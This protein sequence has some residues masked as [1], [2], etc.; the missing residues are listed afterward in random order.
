MAGGAFI[1]MIRVAGFFVLI[2]GASKVSRMAGISSIVLEITTGL[3]FSPNILGLMPKEYS[4]CVFKLY[5][6]CE[7]PH[8]VN[9]IQDHLQGCDY[10][11]YM[12]KRGGVNLLPAAVDI[13]AESHSDAGHSSGSASHS[14]GSGSDHGSSLDS[15]SASHSSAS[16]DS[17]SSA[18]QSSSHADSSDS[19][20]SASGDSHSSSDHS[21]NRRLDAFAETRARTIVPNSPLAVGSRRLSADAKGRVTYPTYTE[22]LKKACVLDV[23][24][25][26]QL[27]PNIF[28][29]VGHAGVA[30]MIFESGMHFDFE[31][32]K[33]VGKWACVVAVLGT[34]L[35]LLTGTALI[36]L[37]V[38]GSGLTT[39][40]LSAGT[41]LAPTSVGIALKLLN[42][43]K[44]LQKD[45]GQI[46]ITAAFVDDILSLVL[47][48]VLFSMADGELGFMTFLP[49]ICGLLLMGLVIMYAATKADVHIEMMLAMMPQN[50]PKK[51]LSYQDEFLFFF[52]M[53]MVLVFGT[54][55]FYTGTHLWGCFMA[56]MCLAKLH[57]AH[58]VWVKQTKRMTVWMIR[59]FFSCTVAFSIP[60]SAL[61][62]FGAIWKG[63]LM[64]IGPCIATKVFCAFF[65]GEMRFVVGWAMVGRA[66]FAYLIAQMAAASN[67]M[68]EDV[69][70]V[71]IWSLLWATVFA[72]FLFRYV[73]KQ[74]VA[75]NEERRRQEMG[76]DYFPEDGEE[77]GHGG[78]DDDFRQ[79]G[80]LPEIFNPDFRPEKKYDGRLIGY[81]Y[82][83]NGPE[84]TGY[85]KDFIAHGTKG[86]KDC[87]DWAEGGLGPGFYI[88]EEWKQ[89]GEH[90]VPEYGKGAT[91]VVTHE[92]MPSIE[93][94]EKPV[95]A[96]MEEG[97]EDI[98]P[99][100]MVK[101]DVS[102]PF[103]SDADE[104]SEVADRG[105]GFLCC[106]F[107]RKIVIM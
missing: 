107:F 4:E 70:A 61:L 73:L 12:N 48:N 54:V 50:P 34:I 99:P 81:H 60:V 55:F 53:I 93:K 33:V 49:A 58:H 42:E 21:S 38:P 87:Y 75:M 98:V 28:T 39:D 5:H 17:H 100:K 65:M 89:T 8:T 94:A 19:H 7:D 85:Y 72:P 10:E 27:T 77:D 69:F 24:H 101:H 46:I 56:G 25:E 104:A 63:A 86:T 92:K 79:S 35:P 96:H 90:H 97:N 106:L 91:E 14:S 78:H 15:A 26:C 2:W 6:D 37:L 36:V 64:G 1:S 66:E 57:S 44:Q 95:T 40:G 47:F 18:D 16:G 62:S 71:V 67:M 68:S 80:H 22:C 83:K 43:A 32:A 45:F 103:A 9:H 84:G 13:P 20:S 23:S 29:F 30:L 11:A 41:S 76:D 102:A 52:M 51:K 31:K 74:Y 82:I 88:K 59:I 3:I 105:S